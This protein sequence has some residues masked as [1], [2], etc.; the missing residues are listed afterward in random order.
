VSESQQRGTHNTGRI[1]LDVT[2]DGYVSPIDALLIIN[3]LSTEGPGYVFGP[4]IGPVYVS[5][6]ALLDAAW[7]GDDA[8][9][10]EAMAALA[11]Q[12]DSDLNLQTFGS[13]YQDYG[14]EDGKWVYGNQGWHFILPDGTLN[15]ATSY[16][17]AEGTVVGVVTR[18]HWQDPSLLHDALPPGG[19]PQA[20]AH[21]ICVQGDSLDAA[22]C[23]QCALDIC[24][25]DPYCCNTYWD[26]L[27]VREVATVC[28]QSC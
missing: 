22:A 17:P 24:A 1:F 2:G 12:A 5:S 19:A 21:S 28:G 23:G 26:S 25:V 3:Y 16:N 15:R 13:F 18:E 9:Y 27:C 14:G 7:A 8:A 11:Y 10:A 6:D 4:T 20:C